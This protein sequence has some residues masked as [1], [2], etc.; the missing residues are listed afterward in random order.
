[1]LVNEWRYVTYSNPNEDI[2]FARSFDEMLTW[3]N[4]VR[5]SISAR[6][7]PSIFRLG[8]HGL[9]RRDVGCRDHDLERRFDRDYRL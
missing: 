8:R 4:W 2:Y 3:T 7:A 6:K 1:M 5:P 9:Q